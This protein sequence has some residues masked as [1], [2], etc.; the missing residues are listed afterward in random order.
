MQNSNIVSNN[1][2]FVRHGNEFDYSFKS[3]RKKIEFKRTVRNRKT[4]EMQEVSE[5]IE[6]N[7][8]QIAAL[9]AVEW[10]IKSVARKISQIL[11]ASQ[12]NELV[13]WIEENI[14]KL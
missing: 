13:K 7:S 1:I 12:R 8:L 4:G 5:E 14:V 11:S 2:L 6:L 10:K 9:K 3:D